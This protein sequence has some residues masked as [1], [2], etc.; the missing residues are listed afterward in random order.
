MSIMSTK[1]SIGVYV[2]DMAMDSLLQENRLAYDYEN[3][4]GKSY[5]LMPKQNKY[6]SHKILT[7]N[8]DHELFEYILEFAN[9]LEEFDNNLSL[10]IRIADQFARYTICVSD[11]FDLTQVIKESVEMSMRDLIELANS[12]DHAVKYINKQ[13]PFEGSITTNVPKDE[14]IGITNSGG[15]VYSKSNVS[16]YDDP[17]EIEDE[18]I[19]YNLSS[20]EY[21]KINYSLAVI[22]EHI[23]MIENILEVKHE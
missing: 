1:Y 15:L 4:D 10:S 19:F 14:I 16:I 22:K 23:N 9:D 5:I 21:D 8:F 7:F 17:E 20:E 6:V 11:A 13:L 2:Y 12:N 18:D 3:E